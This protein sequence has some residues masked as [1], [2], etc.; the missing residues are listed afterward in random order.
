MNRTRSKLFEI[1]FAENDGSGAMTFEGYGAYFG[2][3]DSYGDLIA[4]GSFKRTLREAKKAGV[5][6]V[7]LLQHGGY[8][9]GA[10]DMTPIGVWTDLAEDEKGLRVTGKLADT[11]RGREVYTLMKMD[12][13]PAIDGMSIGY[14]AKKFEIG[15]KPGEPRRK[16]T[17]VELVEVSVVTFPANG[18]ARV[19]AVK[20]GR[21]IRTAEQALRDAGFSASEAKAIVADGFKAAAIARDA[22]GSA[23]ETETALRRLL[24]IIKS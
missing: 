3:V 21:T 9:F 14:I 6:P 23:D 4:P 17:D 11:P 15:T 8:G 7:M 20:S 16:L 22:E 2:N 5:W 18:L 10:E 24:S 19:D 1:K 13:R 12:P